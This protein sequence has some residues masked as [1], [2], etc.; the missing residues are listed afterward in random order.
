MSRPRSS[1]EKFR[2]PFPIR[3]GVDPRGLAFG[4]RKQLYGRPDMDTLIPRDR[5]RLSMVHR[6][7]SRGPGCR[8]GHKHRHSFKTTSHRRFC[9]SRTL[10]KTKKLTIAKACSRKP[11]RYSDRTMLLWT[12]SNSKT[13]QRYPRI[14]TNLLKASVASSRGWCWGLRGVVGSVIS[15]L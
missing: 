15:G 8:S 10:A 14:I 4:H 9:V 1:P 3:T 6:L 7:V 11:K 13:T 5:I 12:D 2:R